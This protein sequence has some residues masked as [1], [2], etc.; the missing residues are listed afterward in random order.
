MQRPIHNVARPWPS[1]STL[2]LW[3]F[4]H[5]ACY[6][7]HVNWIILK[8]TPLT[9]GTQRRKLH[10]GRDQALRRQ[11]TC[12]HENAQDVFFLFFEGFVTTILRLLSVALDFQSNWGVSKMS[13][14]KH[15]SPKGALPSGFYSSNSCIAFRRLTMQCHNAAKRQHKGVKKIWV[16]YNSFPAERFVVWSFVF[17]RQKGVPKKKYFSKVQRASSLFS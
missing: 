14:I 7:S 2:K 9:W 16:N 1:R 6:W 17:M 11:S 4:S 12:Y 13:Q 10:C 8:E 3:V 5:F 15:Q